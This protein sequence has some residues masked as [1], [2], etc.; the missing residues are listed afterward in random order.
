MKPPESRQGFPEPHTASEPAWGGSGVDE[1]DKGWRE[2]TFRCSP[3]T[4]RKQRIGPSSLGSTIPA[5]AHMMLSP[6]VEV[7]P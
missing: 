2:G 6:C 1:L 4:V 5:E 3:W 7:V